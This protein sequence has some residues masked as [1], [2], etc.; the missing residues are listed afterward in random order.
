MSE[1][2]IEIEYKGDILSAEVVVDGSIGEAPKNGVI[3]GRKDGSWT[4]IPLPFVPTRLSQLLNDADLITA[5]E[6]SDIIAG[7]GNIAIDIKNLADEDGI[8]PGILEEISEVRDSTPSDLS[9]LT[10]NTSILQNIVESIPS[11]V[12][13][14]TDNTGLLVQLPPE[15]VDVSELTDTTG[16][17]PK[18][19]SD[20][21]DVGGLLSSSG[22][23]VPTDI[24]DLTD[25]ANRLVSDI[26]E[27]SDTT[28]ILSGISSAIPT[29]IA[30]LSDSSNIIPS[31]I[32]D[33][34]DT[35]GLLAAASVEVT[36]LPITITYSFVNKG[37]TNN[38]VLVYTSAGSKTFTIPTGFAGSYPDTYS[39][40]IAIPAGSG[41]CS[42][43]LGSVPI[44]DM[45][46]RGDVLPGG[47]ATVIINQ[48]MATI[49]GDLV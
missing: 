33:L 29:D 37:D 36:S 16:L 7:T 12:S 40:I 41:S 47:V 43:K 1:L 38:K 14:L 45:Y 22:A 4:T 21:T 6:V 15:I 20:L 26:S 11:D 44:T 32:S 42:F 5:T 13:Q 35:G 27:L 23:N 25:N 31:D 30:N 48:G 18:D 9:D 46:G 8:I 34:T 24:S 2:L 39:F 49:R 10:D 3:H 17:I 28:G 19:L